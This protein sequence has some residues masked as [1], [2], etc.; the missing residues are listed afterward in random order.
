MLNVVNQS[1]STTTLRVLLRATLIAIR[2]TLL[3]LL[4]RDIVSHCGS[5]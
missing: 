2:K 3:S 1:S 5:L 4:T